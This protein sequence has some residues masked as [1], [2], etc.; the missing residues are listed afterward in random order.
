[1]SLQ[2]VGTCSLCGGAVTVPSVFWSIVPPVPTCSRCG[3]TPS[4]PHGPVIDMQRPTR[5]LVQHGQ[6]FEVWESQEIPPDHVRIDWGGSG[7]RY[8]GTNW[9]HHG[10]R[11]R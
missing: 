6:G 2:V 9:P 5:R 10:V 8:G 1:M 3:A 11:Y 4:Q 7:M